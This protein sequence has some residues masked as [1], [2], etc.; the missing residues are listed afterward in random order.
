MKSRILSLVVAL[1][2]LANLPAVLVGQEKGESTANGKERPGIKNS[3]WQPVFKQMA[4]DYRISPADESKRQYSL[5][6]PP[7]FRWTQPVRGGDD[8]ALFVW[9][10]GGRVMAVGTIFA[11]PQSDG[12]RVVQ[13]EFHSFAAEP[14]NAVFRGRAVW[15]PTSGVER[16]GVPDAPAP[17]DRAPQRLRQ[18]KA[19][20]AG[21]S[22]NSVDPDGGRWELR[23]LANPLY[24]Y[25]LAETGDV[26]DG[27]L[28]ALTQGTDPEVLLLIEA[29]RDADGYQWQFCCGRFSDYR[30][31]VQYQGKDVWSVGPCNQ[32]TP[33]EPYSWHVAERRAKPEP[34][35][36]KT[37]T[38]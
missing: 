16:S 22:G 34:P 13:H 29:A 32:S 5:H 2:A 26:L 14:I 25:D 15:S 33:R 17:S 36:E 31:R 7:V 8:G 20:A 3:G 28:F 21:F 18:I 27:A 24:R 23:L 1:I 9:L 38:E 11:W 4:E 30:L 35:A 37:S 19:I 12:L 6:L 10:E